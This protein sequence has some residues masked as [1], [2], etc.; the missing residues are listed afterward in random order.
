MRAK[1]NVYSFW[2]VH[3]MKIIGPGSTSGT[4]PNSRTL[5][6]S[7]NFTG[8]HFL[9]CNVGRLDFYQFQGIFLF[10]KVLFSLICV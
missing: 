1:P 3:W 10:L 7:P 4:S 8:T 6:S 9:Q 2:K 5:G